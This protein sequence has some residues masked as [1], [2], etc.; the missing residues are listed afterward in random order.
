MSD[1]ELHA[2]SPKFVSRSLLRHI[3]SCHLVNNE[4]FPPSPFAARAKPF[5]LAIHGNRR[6]FFFRNVRSLI[7]LAETDLLG[8]NLE[9]FLTIN[10]SVAVGLDWM[11]DSS[12]GDRNNVKGVIESRTPLFQQPPRRWLTWRQSIVTQQNT[13]TF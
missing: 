9:H 12:L 11:L 1:G 13:Y 5:R 3:N 10:D 6:F 4:V 7:S 8:E 2:L